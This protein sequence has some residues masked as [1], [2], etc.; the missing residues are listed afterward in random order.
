MQASVTRCRIR[1]ANDTNN[2]A[3]ASRCHQASFVNVPRALAAVG[4][5]P[6]II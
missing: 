6:A 3:L 2:L 4:S 5:N 1:I